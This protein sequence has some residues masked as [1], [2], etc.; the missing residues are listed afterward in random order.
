MPTPVVLSPFTSINFLF[1]DKTPACVALSDSG[2]RLEITVLGTNG[3]VEES[4]CT[5]TPAGTIPTAADCTAPITI[6][7]TTPLASTFAANRQAAVAAPAEPRAMLQS[8]ATG[9]TGRP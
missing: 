2:N 5:V 3:Q 9:R 1:P 8:A 6:P 4:D 7:F